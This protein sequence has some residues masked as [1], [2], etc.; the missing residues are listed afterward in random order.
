M[1]RKRLTITLDDEA[2]AALVQTAERERRKQAAVARI[3][4]E[5]GLRVLEAGGVD[6]AGLANTASGAWL[7]YSRHG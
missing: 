3:F 6:V 2:H 4:V 7:T 1:R 5:S